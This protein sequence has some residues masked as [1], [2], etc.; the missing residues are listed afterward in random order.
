MTSCAYAKSDDVTFVTEGADVVFLLDGSG[1][2]REFN[3]R[4]YILPYVNSVIN[5]LRLGPNHYQVRVHRSP[6]HCA[7]V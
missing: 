6:W 3:F 1:S 7:I 4:N 5:A 2:V